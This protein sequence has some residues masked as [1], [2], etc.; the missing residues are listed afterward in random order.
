MLT[1]GIFSSYQPLRIDCGPLCERV[2]PAWRIL[3]L[4]R[5]VVSADDVAVGSVDLVPFPAG[6]SVVAQ[7]LESLS[8]S[9]CC[10]TELASLRSL[11]SRCVTMLKRFD[12]SSVSLGGCFL[13]RRA[14]P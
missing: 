13:L 11:R 14:S 12:W 4:K 8:V 5:A 2:A 1:Y 7:E 10:T 9:K 3:D 6:G